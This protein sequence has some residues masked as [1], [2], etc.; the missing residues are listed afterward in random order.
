MQPQSRFVIPQDHPSLPGHFPGRPI[1][2]GVVVL[3]CAMA[4]LLRDRP[5]A[6]LVGFDEVKFVAPVSPGAEI[7]V[8]SNES[9][10]D[11]LTFTCAV[12]GRTVLRGRARL[13]TTG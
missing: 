5:A 1:V 10:A 7:C 4:V 6:H 8:S 11:R 3:G 13:G 9:T 2:P 12:D